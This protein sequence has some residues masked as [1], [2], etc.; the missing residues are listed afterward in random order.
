MGRSKLKT[1]KETT[2]RT[3]FDLSNQLGVTSQYNYNAQSNIITWDNGSE[4]LLKDLFFYPSDPE[5][6]E[7][8]SL[9]LT[10]GF[11]DEVSQIT[12]KAWQIV[13]SRIRFRLKHY[14][15]EPKLLGTCNPTKQWAYSEFYKPYKT[16]TLKEGR[17]FIQALPT[18]NPHLPQ[19]YLDSLLSLDK[20]SRERLY[21]GNWE[22]DDNPNAL[23]SYDD[24]TAIFSN[25]H[26]LTI[27]EH[28]DSQKYITADIARFGSDRAIVLVWRGWNIIEAHIFPKSKTT[29]I[30]NCINAMRE[31][32]N[33][34]AHHCIADED[35]V[36]GGVVD[37]CAIL[38]FK[39][40]ATPID[41]VINSSQD[42]NKEYEIGRPNYNNLQTQCGIYLAR[43]INKHAINVDI[44]LEQKYQ[45]EIIE[46]LE[47]LQIFDVDK[48]TKIKLLPKDKIKVNIGRSP[49]W[50]DVLLMRSYFDLKPESEFVII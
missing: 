40:N 1:L 34:P 35:G 24:I 26:L 32:H 8:G 17:Q 9:E 19:S 38:G 25:N 27:K 5:F 4:I 30:Q 49:D 10:G 36:G 6:D 46:E 12:Y 45:K 2:L 44:E 47:Q 20:S 37:N 23:C 33:I 39:N 41:E 14:G 31:K 43:Q 22:Y 21:Y 13:K 3:F 29:E 7:L 15:V 11:I 42:S 48:D 16:G 50:R 28:K 18:D